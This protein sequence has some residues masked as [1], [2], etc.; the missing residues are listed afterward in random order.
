MTDRP[1][2]LRLADALECDSG[3]MRSFTHQAAEELR[4]LHA[5]HEHQYEMAGLMLREAERTQRE[6]DKLRKT[7]QRAL[8]ALEHIHPGNMTPMAESNWTKAI[9]AL[10]AAFNTTQQT[11]SEECWRW[12]HECAIRKI[13]DEPT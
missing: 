11:H 7:A 12:H 4:R 10:R 13:E 8:E 3:N 5:A 1:I 6:A 9:T 2:A